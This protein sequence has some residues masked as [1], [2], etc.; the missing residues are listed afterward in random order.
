MTRRRQQHALT[1]PRAATPTPPRV[2][3]G[4]LHSP[5]PA[6]CCYH[7]LRYGSRFDRVCAF[8]PGFGYNLTEIPIVAPKAHFRPVPTL[9]TGGSNENV[10]FRIVGGK[11]AR[12][13]YVAQPP[14]SP[15]ARASSRQSMN[16]GSHTGPMRNKNIH[17]PDRTLRVAWRTARL[18]TRPGFAER[19][20]AVLRP[21]EGFARGR[22][23][24]LLL[25][26]FPP[27]RASLII[28]YF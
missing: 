23:Q 28:L 1:A 19:D 11:Q 26:H 7:R 20:G 2:S 13:A 5:S 15:T 17:R 16:G 22:R 25:A 14:C 9:A 3:R 27:S 10:P 18:G 12:F 4:P 8:S 6:S 21:G 24:D